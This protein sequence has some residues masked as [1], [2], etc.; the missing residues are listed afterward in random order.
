MAATLSTSSPTA[1]QM[2]TTAAR[3]RSMRLIISGVRALILAHRP[4]LGND[5][6][7]DKPGFRH[8]GRLGLSRPSC[9]ETR[10]RPAGSPPGA[11]CPRRPETPVLDLLKLDTTSTATD[12]REQRTGRPADGCLMLQWSHLM[13]SVT[14]CEG[15]LRGSEPRMSCLVTAIADDPEHKHARRRGVRP[16][17][18]G[19]P[20]PSANV[21]C[22]L[23]IAGSRCSGSRRMHTRGHCCRTT[24]SRCRIASKPGVTS[25]PSTSR[26]PHL[27]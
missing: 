16:A 22:Q 24:S 26:N 11:T 19:W 21:Y 8:P 7:N 15:S 14:S 20:T 25:A 2:I 1:I 5:S 23:G 9:P 18:Q 10:R 13:V 3:Q 4:L 27:R 6:S 12:L 17:L